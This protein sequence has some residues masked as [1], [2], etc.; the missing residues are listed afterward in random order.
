MPVGAAI[1]PVIS[2]G[3]GYTF[4]NHNSNSKDTTD[5]SLVLDTDGLHTGFFWE[6]GLGFD[7]KLGGKSS[8]IGDIVYQSSEPKNTHDFSKNL[9]AI[10]FYAGLLMEF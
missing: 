4:Y 5:K 10:K 7:W 6:S 9:S 1:L 8:L 3:I 2:G